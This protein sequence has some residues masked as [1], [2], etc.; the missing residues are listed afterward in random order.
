MQFN[1][2]AIKVAG[3]GNAGA[4]NAEAGII[5][6]LTERFNAGMHVFNPAGERFGKN[7]NEK[8]PFVY[9]A[10]LGYEASAQFYT[11]IEIE[12]EEDLPVNVKAVC[13][14]GF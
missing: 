5:M 10:G 2:Y 6:H 13:R 9:T 1:Y 11:S 4:L 14:T 7:S 3:Y 8:L 12:K